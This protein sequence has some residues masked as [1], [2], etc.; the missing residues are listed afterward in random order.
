MSELSNEKV[1][2]KRGRPPKIASEKS[3]AQKDQLAL[4]PAEAAKVGQEGKR[5][6]GRPPG[7]LV[8]C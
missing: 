7:D 8:M 6:R 3:A 4:K 2:K 1:P 5:P